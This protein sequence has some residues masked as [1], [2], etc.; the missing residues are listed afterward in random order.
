MNIELDPIWLEDFTRKQICYWYGASYNLAV[1]SQWSLLYDLLMRKSVFG[2]TSRINMLTVADTTESHV[3]K[4]Y[5]IGAYRHRHNANVMQEWTQLRNKNKPF[6]KNHRFP[7]LMVDCIGPYAP[8]IGYTRCIKDDSYPILW[9]LQYHV[10]IAKEGLV[11]DLPFTGKNDVVVFRG[12]L[13]GVL[14][15]KRIIHGKQKASRLLIV[16]KWLSKAWADLGLIFAPSGVQL[17]AEQTHMFMNCKKA[18][19]SSKDM[20]KYKYVLCIEGEDISSGFGWVLAS[21]CVP[22]CPYPFCYEV[23][24]FNGLQ[25]WIHFVPIKPDGSDLQE[26]FDWC[27][28][29]AQECEKIAEAGSR[30]MHIMLDE[31]ILE[32]VKKGVVDKWELMCS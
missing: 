14:D 27:T 20:M 1:R 16:N 7:I 31:T 25:P 6:T 15:D 12:A 26:V 29:N 5:S 24:Y 10:N 28:S 2:D 8:I 18:S 9:P 32:S 13:S 23:W 30:H 21:H 4:K 19:M 3:G 17:S 22:I 11:D